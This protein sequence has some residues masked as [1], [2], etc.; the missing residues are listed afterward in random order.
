MD[1]AV[2]GTLA[3]FLFLLLILAQGLG[4]LFVRWRQPKVIGE[5]LAGIVMGPTLLGHLWL[6]TFS[7]GPHAGLP[8]PLELCY[9][10]GL[11]LLMFLSGAETQDL[12][13]PEDRRATTSIAFFGTGLP[14]VLAI[15]LTGIFSLRSLM[16]T[17][18]SRSALV[19]VIGIAI[20]VTSIPVI[21]RIFHD[22]RILHTRF[23]K[24]VLGVAVMEDIA[25]WAVLAV[26]TAF[27]RSA[28][29]AAGKI[30][31]EI[32][33]TL[34][35]FA[36]GLVL[37]PRLFRRLHRTGGNLLASSSP[38][39]YVLLI[40]FLYVTIAAFLGVNLVF[41]AFLAGFAVPRQSEDYPYDYSESLRSIHTFSYSVFIPIYFA[42]VGYKL[43]L[44]KTFVLTQVVV[45]VGIACIMKLASV[46][47]GARV[48][49]FRGLDA[50]NLAVAFNAR[51]GP[52]IVLASVAYDAGIVSASFYTTLILTAVITSQA[53]GA[54]L[55]HVLRKGWP[56]LSGV[57]DELAPA[58]VRSPA[59]PESGKLAA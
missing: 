26:A 12:F 42:L 40:L 19:L 24:L 47:L 28:H 1:H 36:V 44:G 22:L 54:W 41:A 34:V 57:E 39:A 16:G 45:F 7:D 9:W 49:G 20:A 18:Q 55:D 33:I 6:P 25:L 52:G 35:Y 23:A 53:A 21:S 48:A 15:A 37:A 27:A 31:T 56:L 8:L 10:L 29:I 4:E 2:L 32:V 51:G 46:L 43:D 14:F 38:A 59:E 13:R 30:V 58:V 17:A 5:I 3:L 11:L 50:V